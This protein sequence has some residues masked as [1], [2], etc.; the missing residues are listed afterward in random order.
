MEDAVLNLYQLANCKGVQ[1]LCPGSE[2]GSVSQCDRN[3]K[4]SSYQSSLPG[5]SK[6]TAAAEEAS[7]KLGWGGGA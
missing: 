7:L 5:W 3:G 4:G 2:C 1:E 6:L